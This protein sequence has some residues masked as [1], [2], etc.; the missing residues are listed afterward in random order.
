MRVFR[1]G[2]LDLTTDAYEKPQTWS[3]RSS[4]TGETL[5]RLRAGVLEDERRGM[6][7]LD[8]AR[9]LIGHRERRSATCGSSTTSRL[10]ADQLWDDTATSGFAIR[11]GL[12]RPDEHQGHRALHADDH[13]PG[14]LVLDPTCG[15]GT[16]AYV[17][18]QWGRRW[19]TIDTSRVALALARTRLM[20]PRFPTT[21]SPTRPRVRQKEAELTGSPRRAGELERRRPQGL[22]LQAR[23]AHHA[24]VDRPEPRHRRGHEPGGDRRSDRAA[25]RTELLFDQPYEDNKQGPGGGPFTVESLS[26]HRVATTCSTR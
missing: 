17:A 15:S 21:C 11:Q 19:I 6:E 23:A 4:S 25:R 2:T 12:R 14:D 3:S 9:R 7:R 16:T 10:P 13:R 22:R 8:R 1:H 20:G 26:P 18:E 5:S 24:E